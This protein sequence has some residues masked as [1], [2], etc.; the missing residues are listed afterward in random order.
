MTDFDFDQLGEQL[1]REQDAL[2]A[3]HNVQAEVRS[4]IAELDVATLSTLRKSV[5]TTATRRAG[6]VWAMG[7]AALAAAAVALIALRGFPLDVQGK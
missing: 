4:R 6:L 7:G 1:A 3:K 2:L 5:A